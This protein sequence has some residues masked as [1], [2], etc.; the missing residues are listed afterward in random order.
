MD[1][2]LSSNSNINVKWTKYEKLW[3]KNGLHSG[4]MLVRQSYSFEKPYSFFLVQTTHSRLSSTGKVAIN[5]SFSFEQITPNSTLPLSPCIGA[6]SYS[7]RHRRSQHST[8]QLSL[9]DFFLFFNVCSTF[10]LMVC[11]A[12][13]FVRI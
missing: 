1:I 10:F 8:V 12:S 11:S 7:L 13:S 6:L 4:L 2:K 3:A 5:Y 9:L